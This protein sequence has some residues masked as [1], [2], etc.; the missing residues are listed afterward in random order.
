MN[1]CH[2]Q[3][4]LSVLR[5]AFLKHDFGIFTVLCQSIVIVGSHSSISE[6]DCYL[7]VS[8]QFVNEYSSLNITCLV[9]FSMLIK[10][11][12]LSCRSGECQNLEI[13]RSFLM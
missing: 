10:C 4:W 5:F 2:V 11:S 13:S 12:L 8:A 6:V 3:V 1:S 7:A 9:A